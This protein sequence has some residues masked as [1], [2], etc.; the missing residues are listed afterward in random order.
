MRLGSLETIA[1]SRLG[2]RTSEQQSRLRTRDQLT[3]FLYAARRQVKSMEL[4]GWFPM[5]V[6][7]APDRRELV[8]RRFA[9]WLKP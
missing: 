9:L 7:V 2:R 8:V 3:F 4:C 6:A 1:N 5:A